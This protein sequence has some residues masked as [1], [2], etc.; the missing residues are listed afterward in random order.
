MN[1]ASA[2]CWAIA[3]ASVAGLIA[4]ASVKGVATTGW[5]CFAISMRPSDIGPSRRSGLFVLMIVMRLG[6]ASTASWS[7]RERATRS[8]GRRGR[9]PPEPETL[10]RLVEVERERAVHVEVAGRNGQVG[11][12]EGPAA[13]L[14]D[15]V[16]RAD[17]ADVV[18]EVSVIAGAPAAVDVGHERRTADRREH[19]VTVAEREVLRRVPGVEPEGRRRLDDQ[20]LDLGRV[21]ADATGLAV[22]G[23]TGAGERSIARSPRTSTPISARIRSAARWRVSTS[24][25]DRISTGGYGLLT[26]RHGSC[27]ITPDWR[28]G[29]RRPA[30]VV[31]DARYAAGPAE[32]RDVPRPGPAHPAAASARSRG[33]CGPGGRGARPTRMRRGARAPPQR[34]TPARRCAPATRRRDDRRGPVRAGSSPG[35]SGAD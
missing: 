16:E 4:P 9:P 21:K 2:F 12:L 5:P 32:M 31:I 30:S 6:S 26:V 20:F 33:L 25:A 18:D 7:I 35:W 11:R 22:D 19:D 13:L 24:S 10:P 23:R 17:H 3:P 15:D 1:R 28:R 14:V 8:R 34:R 27:E 29:R